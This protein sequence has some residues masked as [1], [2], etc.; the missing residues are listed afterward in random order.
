MTPSPTAAVDVRLVRKAIGE[1]VRRARE[2]A[3][4]SRA[5]L[6][7]ASGVSEKS[8][9]RWENLKALPSLEQLAKVAVALATSFGRLTEGVDVLCREVWSGR[10]EPPGSD[11]ART[12]CRVLTKSNRAS[13]SV[14]TRQMCP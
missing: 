4:L 13:D 3:G 1:N 8:V 6:A 10:G 9:E 7:S 14:A 11:D 12:C 5:A 2:R